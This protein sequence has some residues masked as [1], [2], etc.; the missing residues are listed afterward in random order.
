M[1]KLTVL[2]IGQRVYLYKL[3]IDLIRHLT[4]FPL[5]ENR[6]IYAVSG[7]EN[8]NALYS[9]EM[10][11]KDEENRI[12]E[13]SELAISSESNME[14]YKEVIADLN[15]RILVLKERKE[16]ALANLKFNEKAKGEIERIEKYLSENKV[17]VDGFV[18]KYPPQFQDR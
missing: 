1:K 13:L 9:I 15:K 6:L 4:V 11:I 16:Q 10:A 3:S 2:K 17:V 7:D 5:I 8:Y 14:K 12:D 18:E